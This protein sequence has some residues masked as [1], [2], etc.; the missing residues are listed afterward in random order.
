MVEIDNEISDVCA[1][2]EGNTKNSSHSSQQT[3]DSAT[4]NQDTMVQ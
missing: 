2:E 3:I 4:F 1:Y